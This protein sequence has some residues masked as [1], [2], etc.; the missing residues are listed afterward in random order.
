MLFESI[1]FSYVYHVINQSELLLK[2]PA[3]M[4]IITPLA[5]KKKKKK[6]GGGAGGQKKEGGLSNANCMVA[7]CVLEQC[8]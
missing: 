2:V 1:G 3:P 7:L 5:V 4:H 8:L 6:K